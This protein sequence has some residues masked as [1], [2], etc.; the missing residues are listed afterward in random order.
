MQLIKFD[1]NETNDPLARYITPMQNMSFHAP[2]WR[3][4]TQ[5]AAKILPF[6]P[7]HEKIC[8]FVYVETKLHISCAETAQLFRGFV[9]APYIV[10]SLY[11]LNPK[12]F[13]CGCT[14][15]FSSD[16]VRKPENSFSHNAASM[17]QQSGFPSKN[18]IH[19]LAHNS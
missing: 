11:F 4:I 17:L 12:A 7:R 18:R 19:G 1:K 3:L 2:M 6:E 5:E 8:F 15:R 14:T 10:Q 13:F 9:F 16:L